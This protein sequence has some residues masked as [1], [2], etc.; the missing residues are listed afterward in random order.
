MEQDDKIMRIWEETRFEYPNDR[1]VREVINGVRRTALQKLAAQYLRFAIIA[2]VLLVP[3]SYLL[4]AENLGEEEWVQIAIPILYAVGLA[5]IAIMD[6]WLYHGI[7]SIDVNTMSVQTVIS[8]ALYYRKRHL[9]CL[10]FTVP[11]GAVVVGLMIYAGSDDTALTLGIICG[12]C[13]GLIIGINVLFKFL[14]YYR[15]I[16]EQ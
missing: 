12:L 9:Q 15:E 14:R 7:K 13:V 8:K 1:Q 16:S 3:A 11:W 10:L 6:S 5:I 2:S 4:Y